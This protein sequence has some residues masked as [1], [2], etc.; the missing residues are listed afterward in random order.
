[1]TG[2]SVDGRAGRRSSG[3][4]GVYAERCG[5]REGKVGFAIERRVTVELRAAGVC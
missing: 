2:A 1:M 3:L 4:S 5:C